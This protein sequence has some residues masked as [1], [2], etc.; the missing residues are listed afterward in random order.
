MEPNS[1]YTTVSL[2]FKNY[3]YGKSSQSKPNVCVCVHTILSIPLTPI[4]VVA[5]DS[6]RYCESI[7]RDLLKKSMI[8]GNMIK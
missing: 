5:H 3:T 4:H 7:S 6:E 2:V 8:G 1:S